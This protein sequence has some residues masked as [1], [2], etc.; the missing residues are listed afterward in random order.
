MTEGPQR[1]QIRRDSEGRKIYVPAGRVLSQ[2]M[3]SRNMLDI[4]RG[5][6][7]SG[8][9]LAAC[10]RIWQHC[11]EQNVGEDGKRKSRWFVFREDYPRLETTVMET[12]MDWFPETQYG[13]LYTGQKPYRQEMRVGNV[14]ADIWFGAANDDM[15]EAMFRSLEPTGSYWNEIQYQAMAPIF[16]AH[17]RVGRYP[18][19]ADGGSKWSGTICDMNAAPENH[20]MPMLVGEVPIPDD[21]SE[22]DR[23]AFSGA[24]TVVRVQR[25]ERPPP[26]K[27]DQISYFVQPP[28]MFEERDASRRT[29]GWRMNVE[30]ENLPWLSN[31]ELDADTPGKMPGEA[32]Y[33]NTIRGQTARWVRANICNQVVPMVEGEA[34]YQNFDESDHVSPV[35]LE[36]VPDVDVSIG[37]DFGRS[38]SILFSQKI[39]RQRQYQFEICLTNAGATK[40][41][42]Q[43]REL[44]ARHY[45]WVVAPGSRY[46]LRAWGDPK[47]Q[48]KTQADEQTAYDVFQRFGIRVRPAPVVQNA[49]ETRI[50]TVEYQLDQ[51]DAIL[52][53][54]RCRLLRMALAGGYRYP[55][56]RPAP[57]AERKPIKDKYSNPADAMQYLELGEG[58]GMEMIGRGAHNRRPASVTRP[59]RRSFRRVR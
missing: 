37:I 31:P 34:V 5:P 33:R 50:T 54:P 16:R 4:I 45:P 15:T 21:L 9:T 25:H 30:A 52:I 49:I 23:I 53:S 38:P 20:W 41:A 14:E 22:D 19:V 55:K 27:N 59:Q 42:P 18:K 6:V 28:A 10:Q 47:G 12:W 7:G 39:G 2:F 56:E 44:L 51:R 58:S 43:V 57:T 17:G 1:P 26:P 32:Y 40:A 36:P 3:L 24:G 48:D 46:E 29:V 8:K 13:R 35:E 11:I